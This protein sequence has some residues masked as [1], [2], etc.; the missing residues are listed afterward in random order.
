[1]AKANPSAYTGV[2][3]FG[4]IFIGVLG[5]AD[6]TAIQYVYANGWEG[7]AAFSD[8]FWMIAWIALA[9]VAATYYFVSKDKSETVGIIAFLGIL[10]MAGLEDV[11]FFIT[12]LIITGMP[13]DAQMCWF[14]FPTNFVST[15]FLHE[16]CVTPLGLILNVVFFGIVGAV[17]SKWLLDQ[18]W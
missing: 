18:P 2:L 12:R 11:S 9:F 7:A 16:A 14:N 1:M 17:I 8:A 10:I 4:L 5:V 6:W 3:I 13:F 15:T